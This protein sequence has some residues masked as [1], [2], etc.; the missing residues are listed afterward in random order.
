MYESAGVSH[1]ATIMRTRF[2][3]VLCALLV[4]YASAAAIGDSCALQS[5]CDPVLICSNVSNGCS[6]PQFGSCIRECR[7]PNAGACQ[8]S[9]ECTTNNICLNPPSVCTVSF[10]PLNTECL[11]DAGCDGALVCDPV[12]SRCKATLGE[13]CNLAST[14][15]IFGL[16]CGT[17][18]ICRK[19]EVGEPCAEDST[20]QLGWCNE[21]SGVCA[22]EVND[23]ESCADPTTVCQSGSIC[24]DDVCVEDGQPGF[25]C[26]LLTA[27]VCQ[28]P[29]LCDYQSGED[30]CLYTTNTP[31]LNCSDQNGLC[32]FGL[33]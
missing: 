3:L 33:S 23:G 4:G 31:G 13:G 20:C 2:G 15:C 22:N 29:T 17:S 25:E 24:L 16:T 8:S 1:T 5:E 12:D 10:D 32:S 26:S 27:G 21:D 6:D 30:R 11:A 14:P 19:N 18:N 28:F 7:V 9:S